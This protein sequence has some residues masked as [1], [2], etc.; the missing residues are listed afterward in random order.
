MQRID[1]ACV[2]AC[3]RACVCAFLRASVRAC[4]RARVY[5]CMNII[6][7][8]M[9]KYDV[10]SDLEQAIVSTCTTCLSKV[11]VGAGVI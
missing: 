3:V 8:V 2:R 6:W 10:P 1:S 4:V 5:T 7:K 11:V 9:H